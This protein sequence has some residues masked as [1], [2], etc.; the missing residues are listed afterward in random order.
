MT[1]EENAAED[2]TVYIRVQTNG[3][4]N[5]CYSIPEDSAKYPSYNYWDWSVKWNKNVYG[6]R[7]IA[8]AD[9]ADSAAADTLLCD[10]DITGFA[11]IASDH[12]FAFSDGNSDIP[13]G[14]GVTIKNM[15]VFNALNA[16]DKD[17]LEDD[18]DYEGV[19]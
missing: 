11:N 2:D 17:A 18:D 10:Q 13:Q 16:S 1:C 3:M 15:L 14:V 19:T 5:Y 4:P 6:G 7:N 8:S 12:S 9:V